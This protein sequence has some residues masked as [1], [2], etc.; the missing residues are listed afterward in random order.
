[1][2]EQSVGNGEPTQRPKTSILTGIVTNNLD[3][4]A[5]GKVLVRLPAVDQEVWARLTGLGGGPGTGFFH[6]PNIDDEVLVALNQDNVND[7][8]VLGGLWSTLDR[9]PVDVPGEALF[10]RVYKTGLP[11]VPLGHTV[12]FDDAEQSVTITTST[13]QKITLDPTKIEL[14][15]TG[16]LVAITLDVLTQSISIKGL[17]SIEL[18]AEGEISL[19]AAKVSINGE[20]L[21][22]IKGG[23]V[24]IN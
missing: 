16:G 12:E 17:L 2:I 18:K 4:L 24:T 15:T 8:F 23:M 20:I 11:K 9:P 22:D 7:A 6:A 5:Q 19:S 10:K 1:M 3:A 21:T 13:E 14:S